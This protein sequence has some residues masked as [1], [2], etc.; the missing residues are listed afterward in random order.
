ML[1]IKDFG[2]GMSSET[3]EKLRSNKDILEKKPIN[4][5]SM[6]TGFQ[7]C[8]KLLK[9]NR[10]DYRIVSQKNNGTEIS[11]FLPIS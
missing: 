6:G 10:I 1:S 8:K 9:E 7:L 4:Q 2:I 11:L 3:L 5:P